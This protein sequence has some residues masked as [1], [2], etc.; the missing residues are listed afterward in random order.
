MEKISKYRVKRA[1]SESRSNNGWPDLDDL[2]VEASDS[3][4]G[5]RSQLNRVNRINNDWQNNS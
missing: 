1:I 5:M 2:F 4:S 3:E